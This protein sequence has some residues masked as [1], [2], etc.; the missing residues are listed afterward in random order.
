MTEPKDGVTI[1]FWRR[2]DDGT[3]HYA[4]GDS[5][6]TIEASRG[7]SGEVKAVGETLIGEDFEGIAIVLDNDVP[8]RSAVLD[9]LTV[10][11]EVPE[12][13]VAELVIR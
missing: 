7:W 11:Y 12:Q 1:E 2:Q 8:V 3:F 9:V 4:N 10:S 13:P 6:D 5:T